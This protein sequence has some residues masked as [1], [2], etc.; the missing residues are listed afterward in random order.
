MRFLK[1]L[2]QTYM[3]SLKELRSYSIVTVSGGL[4][5]IVINFFIIYFAS[6]S[7][8]NTFFT[9]GAIMGTNF[10]TI[11]LFF[12][13]ILSLSILFNTA[14]SMGMARKYYIPASFLTMV[15]YTAVQIVII[16]VFNFVELSIYPL[17]FKGI[18][19]ETSLTVFLGN[20]LLL[21]GTIVGFPII[22]FFLGALYMKFSNKIFGIICTL[23]MI[24]CIFAPKI[25]TDMR[26]NPDSLTGRLGLFLTDIE[27]NLN[28]AG[29]VICIALLLGLFLVTAVLIL[30]RQRVTA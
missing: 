28:P 23:W 14:I 7:Q 19:C 24:L 10:C 12:A 15:T 8:N 21:A 3:T 11:T 4:I 2:K 30:R 18:T 9:L 16:A 26:E 27:H 1:A 20:P 13:G 5:G 6:A 25:A 22:I 17:F 29:I